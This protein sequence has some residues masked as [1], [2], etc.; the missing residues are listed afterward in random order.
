MTER[1]FRYCRLNRRA[2]LLALAL[3][4]V[5][6][7]R[8]GADV[9]STSETA[10]ADRVTKAVIA[11]DTL[12][13]VESLVGRG[14]FSSADRHVKAM[15]IEHPDSQRAFELAGDV[16]V[17]LGQTDRSIER[18]QAAVELAP[19]PDYRLLDKL[20]RQWMAAGFPYRSIELLEQ[21]VRTEPDNVNVRRD[22]AGLLCAMALER[23]AAE[24]LQYLVQHGVAGVGELVILTDLS[25]PQTDESIC[26]FALEKNP[27]DQR[28][29]YALARRPAYDGQW[30]VAIEDLTRVWKAHPGFAEASAYYG[31]ALV[32]TGSA[33]SPSNDHPDQTRLQRWIE[34]LPADI[35]QQPQYW[36]AAGIWAEGQG[37]LE[38]SAKAFWNATRL[39]ENDGEALTRFATVLAATGRVETS[40]EVSRRA[41]LINAM[42]D[43]V[44]SFFF[45]RNH[46]QRAAV[47]IA[48]SQ[49]KLGRL[50]EAAS[51]ARLAT[52][53]T[54]D[55]DDSAMDVFTEI[56]AQMTGKTAW[57]LPEASV[58]DRI[59][60]KDLPDVRW[61]PSGPSSI[62]ATTE[63]RSELRLVDEA[64]TRGLIHTCEI[65]PVA[66]GETG[67]AI[68]QSGAG[69]AAAIDY[70]L[71][72]APDFY[73][74]SCD[75]TPRAEDSSTNRLFRNCD[76]QFREVTSIADALD[77]GY[78]QGLGV[79]DVDSD[80]FPDLFVG[81]FGVNRLFRNNGDGTFSDVTDAA[82]IS[83]QSWTTSVAIADIDGDSIADLFEVNYVGGDDVISRRCFQDDLKTHRSC[84]PLVFP[85][86]P[87]RVWQGSERMEF[88]DRS[89]QWLTS[90]DQSVEAGR[91]LGL[92]VG[93][94]DP[95]PGMDLYIA[96]D[97]SANHFWSHGSSTE[98]EF[99]LEEQ[100]AVRGLAFDKR[101]LSQASMGIA[102]GDADN[103][104]DIDFY[105]TH[106]T[107]EYNTLYLQ[108]HPGLWVDRTEE[109]GL[110]DPSE[111]M[112]AYGTQW[113]DVDN[114]GTGELIVANG[115]V[116][117]F[118][119][120]GLAYRMPM[121]LF[122]RGNDGRYSELPANEI[123]DNFAARRLSRALVTADIDGDRRVDAL[124][125]HLFDP[126]SLFV[127]QSPIANE[128]ASLVVQLVGTRSHRDA[129]GASAT[130]EAG[131]KR[132]TRHLTAG[133][134]Y[135]CSNQRQL[136]FGLG[137]NAEPVAVTV[138]WPDGSSQQFTGLRSANSYLLVQGAPSP[139][140][141]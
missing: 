23:R 112:L 44:E 110:A 88:S 19:P 10:A 89:S 78:S 32:E 71:D 84:G 38:Q 52:A 97:M 56:R 22:L 8:D 3:C 122:V 129:V 14:D 2:A 54:Q 9:T 92:V 98:G 117:D 66:D 102:A 7:N 106:F 113:I 121:Q 27:D 39:A 11:E 108:E 85:A 126:V 41:A 37:E 65:G 6:C 125:T 137:T 18:Y 119:H 53:M 74:T 48:R 17:G 26:R 87:D 135:Q 82:G 104:G 13:L 140:R 46:S 86:A 109:S 61:V 12:P 79:G 68:Y 4:L 1:R 111:P 134:G 36:I 30:D 83:G 123:S 21:M 75:G 90:P 57:L 91:G 29:L 96:N 138:H 31:R 35:E 59:A 124:V 94:L 55:P 33:N 127:N 101:S 99:R 5:G 77:H 49:E 16:A 25:R 114:D 76:G 34:S 141:M 130:L 43:D 64:A 67:L 105:L 107:K 73:L 69:G 60:M 80:G 58:A 93:R 136:H 70:D 116:D 95:E 81:N 139:Y 45:W 24:H 118:T 50:W 133:D 63:S 100:G 120:N 15:L 115:N 42:R 40:R 28:P 47:R 62:G 128:N 51:W 72:G 103:D 131:G 20:G 132:W